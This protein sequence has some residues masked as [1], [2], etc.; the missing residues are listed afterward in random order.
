MTGQIL[1][2]SRNYP[3]KIG[4]LETF[5]FHLI[6]EF[7][8][9]HH[10][11]KI[12]LSRHARHLMWFLPYCLIK[13]LYIVLRD[14]VSL[15]HLCDGAMAPVGYLLKLVTHA[16]VSA[17]IHGL[18]ITYPNPLYQTIVPWCAARL[19]RIVCVS[20]STRSECVQREIPHRIICVIPNG[21][22][23]GENNLK[24]SEC[25][26]RSHVERLAGCSLANKRILL[27]VGRL[28]RRKG[29][30]WF[31]QQ[32]MPKLD[33]GYHYIVAGDGPERPLL[34][35][36]ID[37]LNIE[38]RVSLLGRVSDEVKSQLYQV[39]DIFIMPNVEIAGDV[40]GFGIVALEA[41]IHGVP[42]VASAIQG[43]QDAV[44]DGMTGYLVQEKNADE[45][46]RCITD[47]SIDKKTVQST[48]RSTYDWS[49]IYQR[50]RNELML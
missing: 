40:E 1:I 21:I 25:D 16:R 42:V 12:V 29:V 18:D 15:I 48:V 34:L 14:G 27:T 3:P 50:Y 35:D 46:L 10:V 41:G 37:R 33:A 24:W 13:A 28:I 2:I 23:A 19:D 47:M 45:F 22:P 17:N 20:R 32:V 43:I 49:I 11:H 30:G 9:N 36:T 44:I 31:V 8:K 38:G 7:E 5:S 4:G 6:R 39:A 26:A